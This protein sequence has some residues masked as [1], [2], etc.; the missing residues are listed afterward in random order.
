MLLHVKIFLGRHI[1]IFC[2][3]SVS[4]VGRA[5]EAL[6]GTPVIT[7][8]SDEDAAISQA[9]LK[10]RPLQVH[11]HIPHPSHVY[12][13]VKPV[14]PQ[15]NPQVYG[16]FPSSVVTDTSRRCNAEFVAPASGHT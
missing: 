11:G 16:R 2:L 3:R 13:Q 8:D 1:F 4:R 10:S 5:Y 9:E 14:W 12:P 15:Q 7:E 6:F